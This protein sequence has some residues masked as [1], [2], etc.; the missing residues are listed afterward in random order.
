M[1][2]LAP[3]RSA[4]Q[5]PVGARDQRA[6]NF[7]HAGLCPAPSRVLIIKDVGGFQPITTLTCQRHLIPAPIPE[8]CRAASTGTG[9]RSGRPCQPLARAR[10]TMDQDP[11][12][13]PPLSASTQRGLASPASL[14]APSRRKA[15]AVSSSRQR[16]RCAASH[17][18][19]RAAA[20]GAAGRGAGASARARLARGVL[21]GSRLLVEIHPVHAAKGV[22]LRGPAKRLPVARVI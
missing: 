19:L 13:P 1:P 18:S 9:R 4:N 5:P 11:T 17:L 8:T 3:P 15:A 12:R 14:T 6:V 21:I 22:T 2:S 7:I 20:W 16:R 10:R